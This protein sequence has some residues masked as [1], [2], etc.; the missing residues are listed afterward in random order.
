MHDL[1]G[2]PCGKEIGW[3]VRKIADRNPP[4]SLFHVVCQYAVADQD[5]VEGDRGLT[6]N[7]K[8]ASER[9]P[10]SD[11]LNS[12]RG[13]AAQAIAALLFA[14][15]ARYETLKDAIY[16]LVA[17]R[18]PSVRS[19]AVDP[20]IAMLNFDRVSAVHL[21]L[22]LCD[23]A[24]VVLKTPTVD[25][26]LHYAVYDHYADL[27]P[28]LLR[29]LQMS[30]DSQAR[31]TAARQITVAAF[32][33]PLAVADLATVFAADATCRQAS[34][35]VYAHNLSIG[36]IAAEC[37]RHLPQFFDD[38]D[39]DV[40]AAAA[41]CF[42]RLSDE[43]LTQEQS[44]MQ[45]FINSRACLEHSEELVIPLENSAITLP[46]IICSL[47]ERLIAEHR[48]SGATEH[49]EHR[50]WIYHLPSL[51]TR[52]YGQSSDAQQKTRC[53]NIIDDMLRLGFTEVDVELAKVER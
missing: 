28:L 48:S 12:T 5:P 22:S 39:K 42:R 20:L 24:P 35:G 46:E 44:L 19:C 14:D 51:V 7:G 11:G 49:I 38:D 32:H 4:E 13:A 30:D 16:S 23:G 41:D 40:R 3:A 15:K 29:M 43:Q 8:K 34:A 21:F 52:V 26:F 27:R 2:S 10:Y 50:R 45:Q 31:A 6:G 47:P 37:R 36:R 33:E 17:D 25:Q 9:D 1:P 18:S 53:L